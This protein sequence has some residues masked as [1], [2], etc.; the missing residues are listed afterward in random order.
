MSIFKKVGIA[1]RHRSESIAETLCKLEAFLTKAKQPF[2]VDKQ[3]QDLLPEASPRFTYL[4][5]VE[6]AKC[7]DLFI[8]LG[9]DGSLLQ[10]APIAAK[11]Q[12]PVVG[13]NKGR[14]GF[15]TDITPT[16]LEKDLEQIL[17]GLFLEEHRFLISADITGEIDSQEQNKAL[18]DI[19][20]LPGDVA[21]MI[22]FEIYINKEFVCKQ[23][24]DG[25][26]I[27]TPTGSTAY[28]LSGGGPI[29][30]P[31]LDAIVLVP[32]FPHTLSNRPIVVQGNS[33]IEVTISPQNEAN[34]WLSCDGRKKR[35]V[36]AGESIKI[37]RSEERVRLIHPE[38]YN[39]FE[40]LR[41]KLGWSGKI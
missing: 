4:S 6:M 10:A 33:L 14:L 7:C 30:Y 31:Q 22:E 39:Y 37:Q 27:A 25:L 21:H 17:S 2:V 18:N 5:Q 23:R 1:A 38:H 8:V 11:A 34:P 16:E 32:M 12:I 40:T 24:A 9:G 26:I 20:L 3:I 36:K 19:V 15:L 13:I 28:A 29:L 35:V 41:T